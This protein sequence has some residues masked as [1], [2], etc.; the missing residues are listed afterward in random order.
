MR[1]LIYVLVLALSL[2]CTLK[3]TAQELVVVDKET[4]APLDQVTIAAINPNLYVVTNE[5]GKAKLNGFRSEKIIQFRRIGYKSQIF[6]FE[7]LRNLDFKVALSPSN[8]SL[9]EVV[10]SAS[11][12]G[13]SRRDIPSRISSISPED[14]ALLAPQT[15]ADLLGAS[16]EVFIQ[17]SQQGGGSPMIRGFSTN[18]L[19]YTI[20]GVRMNTAIFRA[21]NIQNVISLDPLAIEGTEV[22]FGPGAIIYGSDAIGGVMSF[23]TLTPTLTSEGEDKIKGKSYIRYSS[24]NNEVTAHADVSISGKKWGSTTSITSSD[25][26]DL[27]MGSHG[28]DEYLRKFYV[29]RV[30]SLDRVVA[31]PDP[32]LQVPTGY[33]QINLMQ[34]IRFS[35]NEKLNFQYGFH[36]SETSPYS[37]YDRLIEIAPNGLPRS[38][39]WNYGPQKWSMNLLSI[40]YKAESSFFDKSTLRLAYQ[41]FEESRIDRNFSGGNRFRERTQLEKVDAFSINFDF[42]KYTN[43]SQFVYG[44][45][46]IKNDVESIG[47]A[48]DIRNN[49][50][51]A[52]SDR[53]PAS[54]WSSYA[55]YLSYQYRWSPIVMVQSGLRY[56]INR[57]TSDFSRHLEFYPFDFTTS[58]INKAAINESLGMVITPNSSTTINIVGSTG[59][60]A[61]NVDDIGKIFDFQAGQVIVPN[62][63]L[64]AEYAYNAEIGF[65]KIFNDKVK[66]DFTGFYTYLDNAMVRRPFQVGGQD[67]ILYNGSN[68]KVFAIQNAAKSTVYG[69]QTSIKIKLIDGFDFYSTYS[70]QR[71]TEE[72][73]NGDESPS[74]HAAPPFGASRLTYSNKNIE[75][76]LY[77]MY[78]AEVSFDRLNAEERQKPIIYATDDQGN[79]YSP[80]WATL[81]FKMALNGSDNLKFTAG[82]ENIT[83]V[84]Y[85]PYS[86]GMVAAGRNFV[87]A[88]TYLFD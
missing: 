28:P 44:L 8:F 82:L 32:Q 17:K 21:G 16:G 38:A 40:D 34:K 49:N 15:A 52:V 20:D 22:F 37:R 72:L 7:S 60:R 78:S 23:T 85:R 83:D 74:R 80:S 27:R 56:N 88:F 65:S 30:D 59:F 66:F 24:A 62:T 42:Q 18:R 76:Q 48:I 4:N 10:V 64:N 9:E 36:F 35:P 71:G 86:S 58:K 55:A 63:N 14:V 3:S 19:L 29:S 6:S 43:K 45:E 75:M 13:Q 25:F 31:N 61:P 81:N 39:V 54:I 2:L 68:S 87:L 46:V 57:V 53:Y 70:F 50:S 79:P 26:G 1:I 77:A 11:K 69:F 67:S 5:N 12:W 47:S 51:I 84:R 41:N 33:S 73:D